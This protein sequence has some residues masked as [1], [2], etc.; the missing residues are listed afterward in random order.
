M[1]IGSVVSQKEEEK[2][3]KIGN[4]ACIYAD[5]DNKYYNSYQTKYGYLR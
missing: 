4:F 3:K 2:N 5:E 1:Y